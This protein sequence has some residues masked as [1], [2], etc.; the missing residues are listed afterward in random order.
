MPLDPAL[1]GALR[2]LRALQAAERLA[3]GPAYDGSTCL[4]AVDAL[5][6]PVRPEWYSD[7]FKRLAGAA[8]IPPIRLHD[9]RH[10]SVTVMRS[11]G[12]AVTSSPSGTAMMRR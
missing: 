4:M 1:V 5:G 12:S 10:T 8:E 7:T 9:A 11:W 6:R 2:A 3:V